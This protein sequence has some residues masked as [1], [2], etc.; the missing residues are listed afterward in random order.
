VFFFTYRHTIQERA[1][2]LMASKLSA[3]GLIEGQV[4]DEGLAAMSDCRDLTSQLAKEL[5]RGIREEVEDLA[6]VFKRM[7]ILKTDEEKEAFVKRHDAA[8]QVNPGAFAVIRDDMPDWQTAFAQTTL[9][10]APQTAIPMPPAAQFPLAEHRAD[11]IRPETTV[12]AFAF[13]APRG[14]RTKMQTQL[15]DQLSLFDMPA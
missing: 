9:S 12:V 10:D 8:K 11:I 4:T 13:T 15:E 5:T 2:S 3:A 6:G 1:L 14:K 7:A